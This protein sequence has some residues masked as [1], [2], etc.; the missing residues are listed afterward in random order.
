[1]CMLCVSVSSSPLSQRSP[2]AADAIAFWEQTLRARTAAATA[3]PAVTDTN[4]GVA[5]PVS[6]SS[7]T[8]AAAAAFFTR[9]TTATAAGSPLAFRSASTLYSD[10][11]DSVVRRV[12][13]RDQLF[14][15][16]PPDFG[17]PDLGSDLRLSASS[18]V[19]A[20]RRIAAV[21]GVGSADQVAVRNYPLLLQELEG[22]RAALAWIAAAGC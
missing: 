4:V 11:G 3:A 8:A 1:M 10:S 2:P 9:T 22:M 6:P 12:T 18:P 20:A 14:G 19:S 15:S 13:S 21:G 7:A 17:L 16:T 5:S